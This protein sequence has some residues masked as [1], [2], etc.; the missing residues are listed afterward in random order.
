MKIYNVLTR[1]KEEF[2]PQNKNEVKMYAC[3]ITASGEAHIGHAYQALIFDVIRA[4][5]EYKGYEVDYVRN[6]TDVDDKILVNAKKLGIEPDKF[7]KQIM[8]SIDK[9]FLEMGITPPTIQSKATE[10]ITD[11]IEFIE[12]LI[13]K[14]YAYSAGDGNVFFNIAKFKKYGEF[15]NRL[16]AEDLMSGVRKKIQE[17]KLNDRDFALWK[18]A[19]EDKMFWKSPWGKGRPGWHIECS[20]M[21]M[22]Y[23]GETLDIHG[24]GKD[25]LFPHHENEIAQ[26]EALTEKRFANYWIHNGLIKINGQKMSKSLGN[27]IFLKDILNEYVADVL[28]FVILQNSYRSDLNV[29]DGMFDTMEK[30]V[31]KIYKTFNKIDELYKNVKPAKNSEFANNIKQEFENAMDNDFNTALS[32][33]NLFGYTN[34]LEK[35][36]NKETPEEIIAVKDM[37]ISLYSVLRILQDNPKEVC[38]KIVEKHLTKNGTTKQEV[39]KLVKDWNEF[40]LK[41]DYEN[42]DKLR[43][44]L[45]GLN[46]KLIQTKETA[47]WDI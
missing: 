27:S 14:G 20:A 35:M 37:I 46:I 34:K 5:L 18:S 38:E 47:S 26:T 15:S 7:A 31:Y 3:G 12:K 32:I 8:N 36:I 45:T 42:A 1:K 21:S 16:N 22:K 24:G 6:Y 4:Y 25:L 23:L 39:N 41:K 40:R 33:A 13:E 29:M 30:K 9:Q 17:G 44:K 11:I 19:G 10:C 28:K 43:A 2:I